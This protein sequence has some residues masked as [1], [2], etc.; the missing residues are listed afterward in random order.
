M[1]RF[2]GDIE[3]TAQRLAADRDRHERRQAEGAAL[4]DAAWDAA[5]DLLDEFAPE[6]AAALRAHRVP[7]QRLRI[8]PLRRQRG[9]LLS[10]QIWV[11]VDGRWCQ[12]QSKL[13]GNR[14][15]LVRSGGL[16]GQYQ[17]QD[18]GTVAVNVSGALDGSSEQ[19]YTPLHKRLTNDV[20]RLIDDAQR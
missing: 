20:A 9:W 17:I 2:R 6:A 3:E 16:A 14:H 7:T 4:E 15:S 19:R 18:D 11:S 13:S 5:W 1:S 12:V 8:W 10:G